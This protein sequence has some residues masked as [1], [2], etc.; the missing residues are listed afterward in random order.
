MKQRAAQAFAERVKQRKLGQDLQV[1]YRVAGGM[2]SQRVQYEVAVDSVGGATVL[3]HEARL[4][5]IA[6]RASIPPERLDVAGLFEQLSDGLHSLLPASR[7][8]F[9]PDALVGSITISVGGDEE[10]FYFVPEEEKRRR[11]GKS[12][13]PSMD[14]VLQRF[15][16]L[17][18]DVAQA[19]RAGKHE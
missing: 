9:L 1:T 13:A 15:G 10:T 12:V 11:P 14:R 17:A 19:R 8:T 16:S 5:R 18:T 4:D 3:V 6:G 2:P 7:A